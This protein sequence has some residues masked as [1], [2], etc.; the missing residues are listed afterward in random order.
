[1]YGEMVATSP[2]AVQFASSVFST[3]DCLLSSYMS[4][5]PL[6]SRVTCWKA[7][8]WM[9][10]GLTAVAPTDLSLATAKHKDNDYET[11]NYASTPGHL[12]CCVCLCTYNR[13]S[14]TRNL[15]REMRQTTKK[16]HATARI[17]T[18]VCVSLRDSLL[19]RLLHSS[20]DF[21]ARLDFEKYLV[22]VSAYKRIPGDI[23]TNA[24]PASPLLLGTVSK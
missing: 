12:R 7:Q 20:T 2:P 15:V 17:L 16:G 3:V 4:S 21:E 24:L 10:C 9:Q 14:L 18:L 13:V 11:C 19:M 23:G 5:G 1:M 6:A 22:K 8:A